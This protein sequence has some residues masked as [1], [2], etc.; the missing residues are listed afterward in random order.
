MAGDDT[1]R[2]VAIKG[3]VFAVAD[4]PLGCSPTVG[5]RP[6]TAARRAEFSVLPAPKR[7]LNFGEPPSAISPSSTGLCFHEHCTTASSRAVNGG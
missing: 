6:S 4:R 1:G 5:S 2:S 3:F 7:A